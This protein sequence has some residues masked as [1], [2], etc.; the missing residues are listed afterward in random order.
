[1]IESLDKITGRL[2]LAGVGLVGRGDDGFGPLLARRLK[3]AGLPRCID[4]GD[5]LEDYTGDIIR[6]APETI[7]IAD[8]V[9]LSAKP[10]DVAILDPEHLAPG[11][12]DTHRASLRVAMEYLRMRTG[13]TVLLLGIQPER[14]ADQDEL[15]SIV[16]SRLEH[17]VHIFEN[18]IYSQ[19]GVVE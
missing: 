10:G 17:L 7:V 2:V 18:K 3:D 13:A 16:A 8:A 9:D 19:E 15:S 5:R 6:E 11:V 1:M 14:I 4:C 12:G